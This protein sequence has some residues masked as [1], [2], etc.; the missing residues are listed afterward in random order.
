[1][2]AWALVFKA[3]MVLGYQL[4]SRHRAPRFVLVLLVVFVVI[5]PIAPRLGEAA[6]PGGLLLPVAG[7]LAAVASSRLFAHGPALWAARSASGVTGIVV[8]GRFA[9]AMIVVV[10][11]AVVAIPSL[12]LLL[13]DK[14][15]IRLL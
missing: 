7:T 2:R 12:I 10:P 15:I 3:E 13:F 11:A 5:Q 6:V 9:G 14:F 1:M 4:V 8:A